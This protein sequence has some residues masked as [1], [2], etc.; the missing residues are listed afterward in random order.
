MRRIDREVKDTDSIF[1]IIE[2][3]NVVHLGMVENG[4]PYGVALNFG[5]DRSDDNLILYFHC[6]MEGRKIDILKEN[7]NVY[8][9][10]DCVN[11]FIPGSVER[12][13]AFCWRFDSVMGS[14]EI[15]FVTDINE[16]AYALNKLIQHISRTKEV[17]SFPPSSLTRTCVLQVKSNDFTGKHHE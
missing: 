4:K 14:G 16:K 13:C 2:R 6:A 1:D 7:P 5:Y 17:F 11:E 8:F 3:C 9:Q 10:M 12:P 15:E